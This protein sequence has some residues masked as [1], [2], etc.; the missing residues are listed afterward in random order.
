MSYQ[1]AEGDNIFLGTLGPGTNV[2]SDRPTTVKR[3]VWGGS[4]VGTLDVFDSATIAGT[5]A[6][7]QIISL[8][9][10]LLRYPES[11]EINYHATNGLVVTQT[12]TPVHSNLG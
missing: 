1:S 8:G 6:T 5:A 11:L 7:N 10:P 3:I 9:L 4:Y 2:L 12:G